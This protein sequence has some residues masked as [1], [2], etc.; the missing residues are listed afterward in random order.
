MHGQRCE[1]CKLSATSE[2]GMKKPCTSNPL[3]M[4]DNVRYRSS[5][6]F[7]DLSKLDIQKLPREHVEKGDYALRQT[8]ALESIAL[9]LDIIARGRR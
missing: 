3:H 5:L 4:R 7:A 6:D 9:S 2:Q 8:L 1:F